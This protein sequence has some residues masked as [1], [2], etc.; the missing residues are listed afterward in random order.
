MAIVNQSRAFTAADF[1]QVRPGVLKL[2]G[3]HVYAA[4]AGL[5]EKCEQCD[6]RGSTLHD[7]TK[8][9]K[10]W[11]TCGACSGRRHV[12]PLRNV[13]WGVPGTAWGLA[14]R[15]SNLNDLVDSLNDE[16]RGYLKQPTYV[17]LY[18]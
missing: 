17:A 18:G 10:V 8:G 12:H 4:D 11:R 16:A 5:L 15:A 14:A 6:G 9:R 1:E 2:K 7:A 3:H 13:Q